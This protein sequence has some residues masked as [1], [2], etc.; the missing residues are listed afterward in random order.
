[1][2]LERDVE[3]LI[4]RQVQDHPNRAIV[5]PEWAYWAGRDQPVIYREGLPTYL[6]RYLYEQVVGPIPYATKLVLKQGVH[7]RNVNPLLFIAEPGRSRGE[8]CPN[9]HMYAGNEMPS[10]SMGFRCVQCYEAWKRRHSQGRLNIGQINAAKTHC[11]KNH[12]YDEENT[13][14][15]A[16]G[17][18]RCK[19]CNSD[20][21]R[22]SRLRRAA[23]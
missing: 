6:S 7:P 21:S 23:A 17:R 9:G 13:I 3:A 16:S 11:P 8:V 15:L 4:L 2:K 10:N 19:R 5:L 12:P 20:Q 14:H 1:M 22:E 18:R